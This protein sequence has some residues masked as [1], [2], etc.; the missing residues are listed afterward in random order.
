MKR[1]RKAFALFLC[2]VMCLSLFPAS[3]FAEGDA[4][5]EAAEAALYMEIQTALP[6]HFADIV[7]T[8]EDGP[9]FTK[10]YEEGKK[11]KA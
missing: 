5:E 7:G 3:A 11:R 6:T 9:R 2:L 1:I 8:P 10:L 4:A